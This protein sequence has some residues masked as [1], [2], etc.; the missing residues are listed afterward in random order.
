LDDFYKITDNNIIEHG[1]KVLLEKVFDGSLVKAL[2]S[3][4]LD[5]KWDIWKFGHNAPHGYWQNDFKEGEI[6]Q[7]TDWLGKQLKVRGMDDWYRVSVQQLKQFVPLAVFQQYPLLKLLEEA[8]PDHSWDTEKLLIKRSTIK[9]A[10]RVLAIVIQELFP[11]S[12]QYHM[13]SSINNL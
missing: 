5:H 9:A 3:I 12:G 7:F 13:Y 1:G 4:Y 2:Q 6:R 11:S 10:Q 8:Y